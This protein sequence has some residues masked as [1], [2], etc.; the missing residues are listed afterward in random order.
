MSST[1]DKMITNANHGLVWTVIINDVVTTLVIVAVIVYKLKYQETT[2]FIWLQIYML[3]ASYI[4]FIIADSS[5]CRTMS[6]DNPQYSISNDH[7][8]ST[9]LASVT[10]KLGVFLYNTQHLIFAL[11]YLRIALVFKFAFS[12]GSIEARKLH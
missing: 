6:S 7:A 2:R 10:K 11:S 8:T 4:L 1:M 3:L 5:N 12:Y 9:E